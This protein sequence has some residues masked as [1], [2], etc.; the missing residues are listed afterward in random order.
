MSASKLKDAG[1]RARSFLGLGHL[2]TWLATMEFGQWMRAGPKTG[3]SLNRSLS[4]EYPGEQ[5]GPGP[6]SENHQDQNVRVEFE[7][8]LPLSALRPCH[9]VWNLPW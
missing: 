3:H 8:T 7:V 5:A 4:M 2:P 1:I 6:R 9:S